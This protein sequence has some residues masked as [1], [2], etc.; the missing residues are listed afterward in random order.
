MNSPP[1]AAAS[2]AGLC[3]ARSA[4]GLVV[5]RDGTGVAAATADFVA[6]RSGTV[7]V[8][9]VGVS[10]GAESGADGG[11]TGGGAFACAAAAETV[12]G[13]SSIRAG[14]LAAALVR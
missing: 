10:T 5:R 9:G 12:L 14:L 7:R 13:A 8:D 11:G 1:P 3:V 2:T 6:G 4:T